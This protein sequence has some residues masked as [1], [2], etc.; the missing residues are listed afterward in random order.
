MRRP[1]TTSAIRLGALAVFAVVVFAG[2]EIAT[3]DP[4]APPGEVQVLARPEAEPA[5]GLSF[6]PPP[7]AYAPPVSGQEALAIAWSEE[8]RRDA[9]SATATLGMLTITQFGGLKDRAV[10]RVVYA[11]VCVKAHGPPDAPGNDECFTSEYNVVIDAVNGK[12]LFAYANEFPGAA[13]PEGPAEPTIGSGSSG[14][15][16]ATGS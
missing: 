5:I 4:Q 15:T 13:R 8:G 12:F 11:G 6:L 10:W 2:A 7:S 16:G 1:S 14:A 9:T 3:P